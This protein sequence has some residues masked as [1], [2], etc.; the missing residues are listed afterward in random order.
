MDFVFEVRFLCNGVYDATAT[1]T[2]D[3]P[4]AVEQ[5]HALTLSSL[6]IAVPPQPPRDLVATDNGNRTVTLTRSGPDD[7]PPDLLGFRL[8]R[9]DEGGADFTVIG[10]TPPATF[11]F[12]DPYIPASGGSYLYEIETLRKSA[13]ETDAPLASTPLTTAAAL[14]V[15]GGGGGGGQVSSGGGGGVGGQRPGSGTQHFDETT[16]AADEGEP[17][18]DDLALPGAGAIQRFAGRA[19][20]GLIKPFAAALNIAMWAALVLY[21]TRRAASQAREDALSVELE[22]PL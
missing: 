11:T 16:L 15:S 20:A 17:G 5:T 22:D 19:G 12:T 1:A 7:S 2:L 3:S 4:D 13:T 10:T 18:E 9:M 14:R 8:S 21:F 6:R